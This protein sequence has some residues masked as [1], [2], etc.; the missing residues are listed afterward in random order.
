MF[1]NSG[2]L[3][4]HQRV[5]HLVLD[6]VIDRVGDANPARLGQRL[7]ARGDVHAVAMHVARAAHHVA[8]M[9]A[10]ADAHLPFGGLRLVALGQRPLDFHRAPHRR[11][12]AGE[13]D[14]ETVAGRLDFRPLMFGKQAAQDA[15]MFFKQL[16]RERLVALGE[17]A[18]AHH[19][20]EHDG[21]ELALFGVIRGHGRIRPQPGGN[22]TSNLPTGS[23]ARGV[24][25]LLAGRGTN[26]PLPLTLDLPRWTREHRSPALRGN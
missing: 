18:V 15:P 2:R 24:A 10:D 12:R 16:Q 26:E 5:L 8:Q 20:R 21:G 19:V 17:R 25:C 9:D 3:N 6:L 4:L 1:F 13:L 14:E 23:E 11:Q 7:D 22:E